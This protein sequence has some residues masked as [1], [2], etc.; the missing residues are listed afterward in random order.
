MI[1]LGDIDQVAESQAVISSYEDEDYETDNVV[2]KSTI[3]LCKRD[4]TQVYR[5]LVTD[6]I[7][8]EQSTYNFRH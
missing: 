4:L 1:G 8:T 7:T 5:Q 3:R 6:Q 2:L